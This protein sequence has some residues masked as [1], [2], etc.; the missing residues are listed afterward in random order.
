MDKYS[1]YGNLV[2]K[3]GHQMRKRRHTDSPFSIVACFGF[4][5]LTGTSHFDKSSRNSSPQSQIA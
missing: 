3:P 2:T 1:V 5:R 4:F